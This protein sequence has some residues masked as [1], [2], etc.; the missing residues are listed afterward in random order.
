MKTLLPIILGL[1]V[2]LPFGALKTVAQAT[3][4]ITNETPTVVYTFSAHV[5]DTANIRVER[6]SG[7][8][9]PR[10]IIRPT[11]GEGRLIRSNVL[12]EERETQLD[13]EFMAAGSYELIVTRK[14]AEDGTTT[15]DYLLWVQGISITEPY[16]PILNSLPQ[17]R[18]PA[19]IVGATT[20]YEGSIDANA[21]AVYYLVQLTAGETFSVTMERLDGDL[22]PT[23]VL[24]NEMLSQ[25]VLRGNIAIETEAT[26]RGTVN[27]SG[28]YVL[29]AARFDAEQGVTSGR[30]RL[31]ITS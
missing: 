4:R 11:A 31:T 29:V 8:L 14:D 6:L 27:E 9:I 25:V 28:W 18:Q 19:I 5:G 26:L 17:F 1:M 20:V 24:A 12:S 15:G 21:P 22:R 16:V 13:Y 10:L 30:Y 7:N 23:L 3:A 2:C